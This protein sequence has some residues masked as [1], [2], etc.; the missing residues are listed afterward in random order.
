MLLH[1]IFCVVG[2]KEPELFLLKVSIEGRGVVRGVFVVLSSLA[3]MGS[4][5]RRFGVLQGGTPGTYEFRE[6][7]V[8]TRKV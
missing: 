3:G 5:K 6:E 1:E 8:V 2:Q 4:R 7:G